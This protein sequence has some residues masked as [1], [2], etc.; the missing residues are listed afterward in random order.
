MWGWKRGRSKEVAGGYKN[1]ANGVKGKDDLTG[2]ARHLTSEGHPW[3]GAY[4][5]GGCEP[6]N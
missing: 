5:T 2:L 3:S 4:F 1:K 6:R